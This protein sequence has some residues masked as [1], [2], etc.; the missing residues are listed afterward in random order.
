MAKDL[1][2]VCLGENQG[3][4]MLTQSRTEETGLQLEVVTVCTGTLLAEAPQFPLEKG[5][6]RSE[7]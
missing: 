3:K 7:P 5:R 4:T 1:F 6:L 2:A